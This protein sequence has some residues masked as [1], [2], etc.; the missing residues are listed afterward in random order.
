MLSCGRKYTTTPERELPDVARTT[1]TRDTHFLEG[2]PVMPPASY[3]RAGWKVSNQS[4][5]VT[6]AA[7]NDFVDG[8]TRLVASHRVV[9][10]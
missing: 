6:S 3:E 7:V 10:G 1:R 9:R 4:G 2:S 8:K 5:T